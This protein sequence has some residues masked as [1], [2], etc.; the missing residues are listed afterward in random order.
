M[1]IFIS[2]DDE[3]IRLV[4]AKLNNLRVT[5][6]WQ[7][8]GGDFYVDASG[9]FVLNFQNKYI[10]M[11]TRNIHF[12]ESK[13]VVLQIVDDVII[14]GYEALLFIS[15]YALFLKISLIDSQRFKICLHC[16]MLFNMSLTFITNNMNSH[17]MEFSMFNRYISVRF[18]T[19]KYYI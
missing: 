15:L 19:L 2:E 7:K 9:I 18:Y 10:K 17:L 16:S 8:I 5:Q 13:K 4:I 3:S 14:N 1:S 6:G 12:W 11:Q